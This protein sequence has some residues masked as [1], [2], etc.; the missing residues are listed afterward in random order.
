MTERKEGSKERIDKK[1]IEELVDH[2]MS[3]L[4]HN[5]DTPYENGWKCVESTEYYN[6]NKKYTHEFEPDNKHPE[7]GIFWKTIIEA[8]N[9]KYSFK[10]IKKI[11]TAK[12][13]DISAAEFGERK[14]FY[15][16]Y[17]EYFAETGK[18]Q[19]LEVKLAP[20]TDIEKARNL[21]MEIPHPGNEAK[22]KIKERANYYFVNATA[23]G[24]ING[25]I[26]I[27]KNPAYKRR[28]A[29]E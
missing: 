13:W 10:I 18:G 8:E 14:Y 23:A 19:D 7:K 26:S 17:S 16:E 5:I 11:K 28:R 20:I 3:A 25:V 12:G 15:V 29:E 22:Q 1:I 6:G 4:E 24:G 9:K 21:V 2:V 27:V